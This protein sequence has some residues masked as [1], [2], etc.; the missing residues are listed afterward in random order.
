MESVV[1]ERA[2][3]LF[4][5]LQLREYPDRNDLLGRKNMTLLAAIDLGGTH[6]R[7]ARFRKN[8]QMLELEEVAQCSTAELSDTEAVLERWEQTMSTSLSAVDVLI[9]GVAGPV[10]G[11]FQARLSNAP[12][13]IDLRGA[14]ARFGVRICRVVNDFVCEAY[15][16]L[17]PAGSCSVHLL[18][19]DISFPVSSGQADPAP[20]AVLGAGTGMGTGWLVP[21]RDTGRLNWRALPAEAGHMAFAFVGREEEEFATFARARLGV[22]ILRG[23]DIV[24]GRGVA[25]LHHFLTGRALTPAAAAAEGLGQDCATQRWYARFLGRVCAHWSL[26]TLCFQGLFLTGGMVLRNPSVFSHPAFA[27]AFFM[28]PALGILERIPVYRYGDPHSGLWGAAWLAAQQSGQREQ[29]AA[30]DKGRY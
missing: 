17:S 18:G 27:Q 26:S 16:C 11:N 15:S 22:S 3:R 24:T 19:P 25:V 20:M 8:A 29:E 21:Y 12:L 13:Q 30:E 5:V 14:P 2:D 28:A 10:Q 1:G 4:D 9:M 23:D 7:F 6:C